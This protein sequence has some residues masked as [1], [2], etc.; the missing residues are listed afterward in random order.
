M[1]SHKTRVCISRGNSKRWITVVT[2]ESDETGDALSSLLFVLSVDGVIW[3]GCESLEV[4][5]EDCSLSVCN[6]NLLN[7]EIKV[8]INKKNNN[9]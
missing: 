8:N 5:K 9:L 3:K 1:R 2:F 7:E 4:G 6:L